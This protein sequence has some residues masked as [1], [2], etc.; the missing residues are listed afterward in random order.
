[1]KKTSLILSLLPSL[2]L[3][4]CGG[5][6]ESPS[7]DNG[8]LEGKYVLTYMT[9]EAIDAG[10]G[11]NIYSLDFK[12]DKT[13]DILCIKSIDIRPIKQTM[14]YDSDFGDISRRNKD[15]SDLTKVTFAEIDTEACPD[16][17]MCEGPIVYVSGLLALGSQANFLWYNTVT[18][19]FS[20]KVDITEEYLNQ[21]NCGFFKTL[22]GITLEMTFEK[23]A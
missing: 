21:Y 11:Y 3:L 13:L 10:A 16:G 14:R 18:D 8:E 6:E 7:L 22:I 23:V 9:Q 5:S 19:I 15:N 17:Q 12:K 4:S 20:F 2:L 1:M